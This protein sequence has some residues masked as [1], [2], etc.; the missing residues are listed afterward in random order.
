MELINTIRNDIDL[1]EKIDEF[2]DINIYPKEQKPEN[3]DGSVAWNIDGLAFGCD[4]SGGEY[5]LL[6]DGSVG[7]NGS[8]GEC[9]RVA[10]NINELF[11][12]LINISC[13]MDYLRKEL[14]DN[15]ETLNAYILETEN[16]YIEN[17]DNGD[18]NI[19]QR[20]LLD[21]LSVK[22]YE[23]KIDLVKR[24]YETTNREPK[25]I[26]TFTEEDGSKHSTNGCI[27]E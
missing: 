26:C 11:E 5:I 20:E 14:Y 2:C 3:F 17:W 25:Y 8:E 6:K 23:N 4:A 10:E 19:M 1:H 27:I 9:G 13:W 21:K 16:D 12:L 24:F 7:F 18:Y 22:F 15:D